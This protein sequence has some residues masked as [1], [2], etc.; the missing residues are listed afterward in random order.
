MNEYR[1]MNNRQSEELRTIPSNF[2]FTEE[3]IKERIRAHGLAPSDTD[4]ICIVADTGVFY[5]GD[6]AIRYREMRSRHQ[7]EREDAIAADKSGFGFIYQMFLATL[8][9][10]E[11]AFTENTDE[12]LEALG[13]ST[14]DIEADPRLKRGLKKACTR[15]R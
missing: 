6:N 10:R 4:R 13:Y 8:N 9:D 14:A 11:Y 15:I 5:L 3:M 12:A 1:N 7:R 2:A